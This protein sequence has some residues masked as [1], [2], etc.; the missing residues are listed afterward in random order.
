M[1]FFSRT[2][3]ASEQCINLLNQL[4]LRR[5]HQAVFL[6]YTPEVRA[7][8]GLLEPYVIFGTPSVGTVRDLIFK[9]GF[10]KFNGK[11]VK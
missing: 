9:Y 3:I 5:M 7:I 8:L 11:K 4:N 1:T 10:I 6:R 2:H